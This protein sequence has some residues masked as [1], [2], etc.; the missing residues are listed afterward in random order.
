MKHGERGHQVCVLVTTEGEMGGDPGWGREE[1]FGSN[2]IVEVQNPFWGGYK[3][4]RLPLNK[5]IIT[6]TGGVIKEVSPQMIFV[7]FL[8]YSH[9]DHR[10]LAEAPIP[11]T[12][13]V[14]NILFYEMPTTQ[15]F[16]PTV[17]VD[18]NDVLEKKDITL[19]V[20][21]SQVVKTN[22]EGTYIIDIGRASATFRGML[23][24]IRNAEGFLHLRLFISTRF[25][26]QNLSWTTRT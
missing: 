25:H 24:R 2:R 8:D 14:K 7:H 6:L 1:Q 15:N 21:A 3:D 10:I 19:S 12:R 23:G 11:A 4:T 26:I 18:I 16:S 5:V 22:I 13:Y 9:Q 20:H 17:F